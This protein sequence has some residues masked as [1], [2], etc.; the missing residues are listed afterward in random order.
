VCHIF[1]VN[2]KTSVGKHLKIPFA[3]TVRYRREAADQVRPVGSGA[4][5]CLISLPAGDRPVIA[6][7]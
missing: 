1:C 7:Q 2:R 6:G 4:A 3:E 5:Q